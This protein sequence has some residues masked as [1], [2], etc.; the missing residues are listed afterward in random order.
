LVSFE[1]NGNTLSRID[2]DILNFNRIVLD[3]VGF[4][5]SDIVIINREGEEWSA[6]D[7]NDTESVALSALDVDDGEWYYETK[8][9]AYVHPLR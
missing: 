6:R 1:D 5:E 3:T 7:G 8:I 9:N 4:H 2:V